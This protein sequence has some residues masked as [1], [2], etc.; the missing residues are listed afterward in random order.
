MKVIINLTDLEVAGIKQYLKEVGDIP[1]PT[2]K[3]IEQLVASY[4]DTM[5]APQEALSDYIK[6]ARL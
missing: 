5:N 6:R 2:K 1:K 4:V 3:D